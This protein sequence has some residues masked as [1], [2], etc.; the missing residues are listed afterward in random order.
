MAM[1][2]CQLHNYCINCQIQM[3]APLCSNDFNVK[4]CGALTLVW[5]P[6]SVGVAEAAN[7]QQHHCQG[8]VPFAMEFFR[9]GHHF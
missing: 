7:C 9:G 5:T 2:L 3:E 6:A 4:C 1:C 8:E